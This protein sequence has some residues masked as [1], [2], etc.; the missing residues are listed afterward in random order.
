MPYAVLTAALA[1]HGITLFPGVQHKDVIIQYLRKSGIAK[2]YV[3]GLTVANSDLGKFQE[4]VL[5]VKKAYA[6]VKDNIWNYVEKMMISPNEMVGKNKTKK[7][8]AAVLIMMSIVR[9]FGED[10]LD[11]LFPA[12]RD[13]GDQTPFGCFDGFDTILDAKI[14]A[15]EISLAN[16]NLV[17]SGTFETPV[18]A[19]DTDAIDMM[20]DWVRNANP[21]LKKK[22]LL[23]LPNDIAQFCGD[24]LANKFKYKDVTTENIQ[25]YIN[26][27]CSS[28]IKVIPSLIM[29]TGQRIQL[30]VPGNM[31]FGMNT[32]S[33]AEFVQVREN[34]YPDPNEINYWIQADYGCRYR[35]VHPKTFMMNEG[36]AVSNSL[37]GDYDA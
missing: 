20:V 3:P 2:P 24:A 28:K 11:A 27:K 7:H 31:D 19:D 8:P 34:M 13:V 18:N 14:A 33:D 9:T 12:V 1:H 5:E 21:Y 15:S 30:T 29:G 23:L 17:N 32:A 22:A 16:K 4:S 10:I 35:I 6:S 26:Q 25:N 36:A 37:S